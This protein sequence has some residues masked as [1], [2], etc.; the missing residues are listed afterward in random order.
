MHMFFNY[1]KEWEKREDLHESREES[2][3]AEV[4]RRAKRERRKF[5]VH[6]Q[7]KTKLTFTNLT[8]KLI[9]AFLHK[10]CEEASNKN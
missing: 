4:E 6:S 1:T 5:V 7:R 3:K 9:L 2:R 8:Y 10:P